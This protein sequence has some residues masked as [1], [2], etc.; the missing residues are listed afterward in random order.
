MNSFLQ[1]LKNLGTTRLIAM[2]AVGV[3]LMGLLIYIATSLGRT[4]MGVLFSSLD[5]DSAKTII[6]KLEE[7][8]IPYSLH[9]NGA[10]IHVP[11]T[12]VLKL[13]VELAETA[14]GTGSVVGYELF[15][16]APS[17]GMGQ[18]ITNLQM[19]RALEGEL[20]RTIKAIDNVDVARVHLV[21]PKREMFSRNEQKPSA[22][23]VVKM[24]KGE[25][26]N[27]KQVEAVQ[28]LVAAA[29]P[30]MDLQNVSVLDTHGTLLTK[31]YMDE[32]HRTISTNE[33]LRRDYEQ[34]MTASVQDLLERSVGVG[35][36]RVKINLEMDFDHVVTNKEIY[37]PDTQV[38][39]SS[40]TI[41]ES[42]KTDEKEPIVSVQQNLPDA[43]VQNANQVSS[44]AN[45]TE[46]TANYEISKQVINQVRKT[47]VIKRV[48]AAVIVDGKYSLQDNGAKLYSPRS[49]KE[50]E[51]LTALVRSAIGFDAARGDSLE[52]VN[53]PFFNAEDL[54]RL[55]DPILFMGFSKQEIIKMSESLGVAIVAALVILLVVRPLVMKAFEP[56]QTEE[57]E[58]ALMANMAPQLTNMSHES[59]ELGELLDIA[60]IE[61][62]VKASSVKKIGELIDNHPEEALNILRSWMYSD[63]K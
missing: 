38:L 6:E 62:R 41:E 13:R 23:V 11:V 47:G 9:K 40:T 4:E 15:D 24:K 22:S 32:E 30:K 57:E 8:N 48:S 26:L 49:E 44:A 14:D 60:K 29:V 61:G 7:R 12:D 31:Q 10:E 54:L 52:V 46:E 20:A 37:D 45:R 2:G 56:T 21:L 3:L 16:K 51:L 34:R 35:N 42:S 59:D 18:D 43:E 1:T 53:L 36:V 33:E 17:P 63:K 58:R 50:M 55:D 39:R 27:P 28:R 25:S 5:N 19:L